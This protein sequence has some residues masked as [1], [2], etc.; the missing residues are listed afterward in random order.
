MDNKSDQEPNN[1]LLAVSSAYDSASDGEALQQTTRPKS[2]PSIP[3]PTKSVISEQY[4]NE[5]SSDGSGSES[6]TLQ[7]RKRSRSLLVKSPLRTQSY[8]STTNSSPSSIKSSPLKLYQSQDKSLS[9]SSKQD[10]LNSLQGYTSNY[11]DEKT[12]TS[13]DE[14]TM[15]SLRQSPHSIPSLINDSAVITPTTPASKTNIPKTQSS[16]L[17]T[18]PSSTLHVPSNLLYLAKKEEQQYK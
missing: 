16:E 6:K 11:D 5:N 12:V 7:L 9:S 2:A 8:K 14:E 15:S 17:T 18:K 10:F 13:D 3:L 1:S 4:N